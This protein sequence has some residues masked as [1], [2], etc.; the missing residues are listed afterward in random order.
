M[1]DPAPALD[2]YS[3]EDARKDENRKT[4]KSLTEATAPVL[5]ELNTMVS[6]A[7]RARQPIEERWRNSELQ[8]HGQYDP[9]TWAKLQSD[10]AM[11]RLFINITRAKTN[12]WV[13]RLADMLFPNDEKNWGIDPTPLPELTKQASELAKLADK[14]DAEAAQM[15]EQHNAMV[16]QEG[17][18]VQG[19]LVG[20]AAEK[21]TLATQYREQEKQKQREI[22]VAQNCTRAMERLIDDQLTESQ[23]PARCRDVIEDL[24]KV[25]CGILKGPIINSRPSQ[26]W[27][28]MTEG[29]ADSAAVYQ[30]QPD[31]KITPRFRRVDYRHFFPDPTAESMDDCEY[32]F[33]RHLPNK[34]MLRKMAE[35]LEFFTPAVAE[36]LKKG[37]QGGGYGPNTNDTNY[38]TEL[39]TMESEG[40][41]GAS[42]SYIDPLKNRYQVW[43]YHGP[44]EAEQIAAMLRATGKTKDADRLEDGALLK[45]PMVRVFFCNDVLLKIE[46]EYIL[47]SGASLYSVATFERGDRCVLGGVGV[48]HLMRNEQAMLNSAVR[49]MMDNG[50]L[51][52]GPQVVIDKEAITPENGRWKLAPRKVWQWITNLGGQRTQKPFETYDIP[53]NQEFL[54]AIIDISLRF[55]DEVIA[56][57]LIAQGEMGAHVT[58]TSSGMSMLFNSANVGFRRVVKNWDD[59]LTAGT[60]RRTYDFNMQFS[61][62]DSV[63]GDMKTEARGTSVLLVREMQAEQLMQLIREWAQHP[64][65]GIGFRAYHAMRLVLQAMSINPDD[66]LL[67]EDEYLAKLKQMSENSGEDGADPDL[68]RAQTAL[69]VANIDAESRQNV[70][71]TN[72]Q[73]AN[74]RMQADFASLASRENISLQQIEAMF[75]KGMGEIQAKMQIAKE[76]NDSKERQ[77]AAELGAE[78]RAKKEAEAMGMTIDGS[79][80]SVNLAPQKVPG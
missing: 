6:E 8:Y 65:I 26:R 35:E 77:F 7:V 37:P 68:I 46:D 18:P 79:G 58:K 11:S 67:P 51:A 41:T 64:V 19:D 16:E 12:A 73:I 36:L 20:Q 47:D 76:N 29:S 9:A 53:I 63:K 50:A 60:I 13:S 71:N 25:G 15:D 80:G 48:P 72:L 24:C 22:E 59:D 32:T 28:L 40:E 38:L 34:K 75:Q 21:R 61:D 44:L 30:L 62:D 14:L 31:K 42:S 70:A 74:M 49:M 2:F 43:E 69:E 17:G 57:P 66:L 54:A 3:A 52:V 1:A 56:M 10:E 55:I 5:M 39:R 78:A 27:E 23:Y 33:E 45:T 4:W